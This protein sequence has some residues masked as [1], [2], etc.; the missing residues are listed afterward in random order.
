MQS[1]LLK[2]LCYDY[3]DQFSL[4]GELVFGVVMGTKCPFR[5]VQEL[6]IQSE[7]YC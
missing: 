7:V 1:L 6:S 4:C 2:P 3:N 5:N